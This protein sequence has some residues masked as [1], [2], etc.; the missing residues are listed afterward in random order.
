MAQDRR[1]DG[2]G[3]I[4]K[5]GK[6]RCWRM[7]CLRVSRGDSLHSAANVEKMSHGMPLTDADRAPW[8]AA[9]IPPAR[10]LH[11]WRVSGRRLLGAQAIVSDG[12]AKHPDHWV[13]LKGSAAL[14]RSRLQAP[15]QPLHEGGHAGQPVRGIGRTL[16]AHRRCPRVTQRDRGTD[17]AELRGPS[18]ADMAGSAD[19]RK[20]DA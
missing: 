4:R 7:R 12:S 5:N 18:H 17:L 3:W 19:R 16:H 1:G 13:Y 20:G 6:A 15:D 9:I 10:L 8:L 14:I 2:R 11:A